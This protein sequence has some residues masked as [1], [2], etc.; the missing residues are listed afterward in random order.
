[1]LS[2]YESNIIKT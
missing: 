2:F 1:M